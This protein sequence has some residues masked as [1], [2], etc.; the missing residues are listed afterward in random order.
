MAENNPPDFGLWPVMDE[1]DAAFD[2]EGV[3]GD[4]S[5]D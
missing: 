5:S 4:D 3:D 2:E 1:Y